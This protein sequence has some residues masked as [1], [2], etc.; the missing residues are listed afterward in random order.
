MIE[1]WPGEIM[2]AQVIV[3]FRFPGRDVP[4][5]RCGSERIAACCRE[6]SPV[7]SRD[8]VRMSRLWRATHLVR[9]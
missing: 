2:A 8:V 9:L 4:R 1:D 5:V 7:P 3:A 6:A